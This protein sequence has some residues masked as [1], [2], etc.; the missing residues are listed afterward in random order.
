MRLFYTNLI[1]DSDVVISETSEVSTLPSSNV[2]HELRGKVW[3]TGTSVALE[4]VVFDLGSAQAVTACIILDH[5]ITSGDSLIRIQGN[6]ADSWGAPA[7][8][9][10]IT[11]AAD[12]MSAV[13]AS[14]SYR[15][16]R[17]TFTKSAAGESRDVGRIFLG[18]YYETEE[19]PDYD[20]LDIAEN[21][22]SRSQMS[23]GG[24]EY[25]E[26]LDGWRAIK[27]DFTHISQTMK[28]NLTTY[29]RSVKQSVSHFI[30]VGSSSPFDAIY[31]VK[32]KN[33]PKFGVKAMDASAVW[34]V[35][36]DYKEQL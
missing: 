21:D 30:Q 8:S 24:Q 27:C 1:D 10:T 18:T 6:T 34:D 28:D 26:L 2:A 33:A 16:W 32:L 31:Y 20:G 17:F 14:Q 5:T 29:A 19:A 22:L 15:Y 36:L 23:I 7:F 4:A 35:S 25:T 11:Y 13:F 12:I 3:R 9:Q